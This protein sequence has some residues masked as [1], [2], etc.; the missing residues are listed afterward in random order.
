[1][2]DLNAMTFD[3]FKE[4]MQKALADYESDANHDADMIHFMDGTQTVPLGDWFEWFACNAGL[5]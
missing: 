4:H 3:E 2:T 1:M 5:M